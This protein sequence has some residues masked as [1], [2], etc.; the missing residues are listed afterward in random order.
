VTDAN[1]LV[2]DGQQLV[3]SITRVFP[4]MDQNLY[5]YMES[6]TTRRWVRT[7]SRACRYTFFLS[8][9]RTK[10]S[11]PSQCV[12][13]LSSRSVARPCLYSFRLPL[14]KLPTGVLYLPD[15]PDRRERTQIRLQRAE[16]KVLPDQ[17]VAAPAPAKSRILIRYYR[18]V[19]QKRDGLSITTLSIEHDIFE[20]C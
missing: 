9:A 11:S 20:L 18:A 6:C 8:A 2:E 19:T 3:P 16:I 17:G 5:V 4:Q 1:P 15:Q 7:R 14:V 10:C 12:W 13:N